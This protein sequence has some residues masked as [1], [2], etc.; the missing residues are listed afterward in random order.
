MNTPVI[1]AFYFGSVE[2]YA[3]LARHPRV[4]IDTGEHYERQSYRTRTSIVGPNGV[5][6]LNVQIARDHGNK[7]PMHS[8]G[9]SYV[10]TWPQQHLHAIR[11]AYGKTPWF[12]HYIDSIEQ[13]ILQPYARL[14]D[15]QLAT[16]RLG[17]G[18]LGLRTALH[19][20]ETFIEGMAFEPTAG[21]HRTSDEER[22]SPLS[23]LRSTFNPKRPLPPEV[24]AIASYHQVFADRH[25]FMPRLSV[26]D[27]VC[28]LGPRAAAHLH[29]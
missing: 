27:L 26:I 14:I 5:Q 7:M 23:D 15:L 24:P 1:S 12:I 6:H 13:V 18:W 8:V 21:D 28:N 19:I 29:R 22:R 25:G 17:M 3:L 4:I 20:S 2:H 11:S 9:L 10:E 16:M